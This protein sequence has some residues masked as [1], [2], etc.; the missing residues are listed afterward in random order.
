MNIHIWHFILN[1]FSCIKSNYTAICL[2]IVIFWYCVFTF[3]VSGHQFLN[4]LTF[5]KKTSICKTDQFFIWIIKIEDLEK[6][7]KSVT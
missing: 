7:I 6:F 3:T 4:Y 1:T 2:W 5:F